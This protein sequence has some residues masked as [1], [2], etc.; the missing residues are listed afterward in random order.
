M[1][2]QKASLGCSFKGVQEH[3]LQEF[4]HPEDSCFYNCINQVTRMGSVQEPSDEK[5]L[6]G[7]GDRLAVVA[8]RLHGGTVCILRG[9]LSL[10]VRRVRLTE[11]SF[12]LVADNPGVPNQEV[13]QEQ[14]EREFEPIARVLE[15]R[16]AL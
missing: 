1:A 13:S 7:T 16:R 9:P 6:S 14:W 12:L 3:V 15:V 11:S 5:E 2:R 8:E 4:D 10:M